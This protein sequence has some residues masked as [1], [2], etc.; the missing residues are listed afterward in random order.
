MKNATILKGVIF[1]VGKRKKMLEIA[2]S[3]RYKVKWFRNM[4]RRI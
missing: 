2:I 1:P 3:R 4:F